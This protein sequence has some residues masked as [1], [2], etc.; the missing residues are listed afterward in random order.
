MFIHYHQLSLS[1]ICLFSL[2]F[3]HNYCVRQFPSIPAAHSQRFLAPSEKHVSLVHRA[4]R[5][6]LCSIDIHSRFRT[7]S[8]RIAVT[9][10]L[11]GNRLQLI[12]INL[13]PVSEPNV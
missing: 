5:V 3:L 10:S 6:L 11:S 12:Y 1:H 8:A 2:D 13:P 9:R 4:H 7:E